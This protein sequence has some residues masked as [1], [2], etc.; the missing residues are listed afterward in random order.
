M[1]KIKGKKEEFSLIFFVK[2]LIG[3]LVQEVLFCGLEEAIRYVSPERERERKRDRQ[4]ERERE[5]HAD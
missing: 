1:Y 4:R 5:L 3:C 2:H